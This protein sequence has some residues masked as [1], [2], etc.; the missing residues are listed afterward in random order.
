MAIASAFGGTGLSVL[1]SDPL[2]LGGGFRDTITDRV[3][4]WQHENRAF[5]GYYSA[6]ATIADTLEVLED[7]F[8]NGLGR[9]IAVFDEATVTL[10][11]GFVNQIEISAGPIRATR[12]PLLN[13]CNR[14][15]LWYST[16]DTSTTPPTVGIRKSVG[17]AND[18]VSQGV[19]SIL[20][21]LLSTGGCTLA[22][23]TQLRDM[24]LDFYAQ[25]ETD[26]QMGS[27]DAPALSIEC[28]GWVRYLEKYVFND[29]VSTGQ[30]NLSTKLASILAAD[31]NAL[32][33][34][35]ITANT[36]QVPLYENDNAVAWDLIKNLVPLGDA[37]FNRYLF[38]IY[39]NR[40]ARYEAASTTV[41]YIQALR[42]PAQQI[43]NAA[44]GAARP[45]NIMPGK[46]LF[47]P[48]FLV[49]RVPVDADLDEDP[50]AAF[51]ESV[52]YEAPYGIR[53]TSSKSNRLQQRLAQLGLSG[54]GA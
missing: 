1:V 46:W 50:R 38:G 21:T 5:G 8:V 23:A 40:V 45:W 3:S 43:M 20:Q 9:Q 47:F 41:D 26:M 14:A 34:Q 7:W 4:S 42:D 13:V 10:W 36:F 12:G 17:V 2:A 53:W 18:T 51:L 48:D 49:G 19:Y 37:A 32:F 22:N 25:P 24:H 15:D 30:G 33:T 39:A 16:V 29:T 35:E 44:G 27:A 31:P 52:T 54:M 28:A 6:R 11:E